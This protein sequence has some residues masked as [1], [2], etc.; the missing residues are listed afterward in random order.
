MALI[1]FWNKRVS[2]VSFSKSQPH[3]FTLESQRSALLPEPPLTGFKMRMET[4]LC[5]GSPKDTHC[6]ILVCRSPHHEQCSSVWV[7]EAGWR[8]LSVFERRAYITLENSSISPQILRI[9]YRV[10]SM[11]TMGTLISSQLCSQAETSGQRDKDS[12]TVQASQ[13]CCVKL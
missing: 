10:D 12:A 5:P 1:S 3:H 9:S 13:R 6:L 7:S 11:T 4:L 8:E 2:L